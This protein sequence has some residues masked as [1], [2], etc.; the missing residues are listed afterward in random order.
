KELLLV[1]LERPGTRL[2]KKLKHT[3]GLTAE[4]QHALDQV[5]SW[6]Q[7]FEDHRAAALTNIDLSIDEV[8]KVKGVVVAGRT[9]TTTEEARGLRGRPFDD[10]ELFTYDDLLND[11]LNM[12]RDV[13]GI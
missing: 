1:E 3:F 2:Q 12:L 9:P 4:L 13:A 8:A 6:I 10:V 5:R 7:V 11:F